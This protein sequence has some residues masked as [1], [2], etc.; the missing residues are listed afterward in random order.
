MNEK[1]G[2]GVHSWVRVRVRHHGCQIFIDLGFVFTTLVLHGGR[3]QIVSNCSHTQK[4]REE[5]PGIHPF[6]QLT[7]QVNNVFSGLR[8][9]L[10][11]I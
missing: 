9:V 6:I 11:P 4:Q 7:P 1:G 8:P 5:N 2:G 3:H 10:H